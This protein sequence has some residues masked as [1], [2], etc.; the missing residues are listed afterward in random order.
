MAGRSF[1]GNASGQPE[2]IRLLRHSGIA[3]PLW[4]DAESRRLIDAGARQDAFLYDCC[5]KEVLMSTPRLSVRSL[6]V[7][8]SALACALPAMC[9]EHVVDLTAADGTKLKAT[10]FDAGKPG[11]GVLLLH[12]CNRQRKVWDGLALQLSGAG[13]NVLTVDT[14]GFG[15]SGGQRYEKLA[16]QVEAQIEKEK[17]P[18]D[19]DAAIQYLESQPGVTRDMIGVGGASCGVNNSIQTA[20]RHPEV[21]SLVLLSGNT[22]LNGRNYL[23]NSAKTPVFF[24]VADDDEFP[25]TVE[26]IEWLYSA[27]SNPGKR[28][29]HFTK[30]GHGADMFPVHPELPGAI[31]DWYVTTLIKTPGR[32]PV[33][34]DAPAIPQFARNLDLIDQPGGAGKVAAKLE[35][36]RKS[37]PTATLFPEAIVNTIG[38]EHLQAGDTKDAIEI[39][40]LNVAGF[41]QSPNT[42]DSLSD[43][44]MAAGQK[45]LARENVNKA[46][47]LLPS[48]TKD[49]APFREG[50][51]A[52]DEQKL[53]DL[54][55][56]GK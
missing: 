41:P 35:A 49:P 27:T 19:F 23:R 44:Y 45:D 39:F 1:S 42:Y 7:I 16:P 13:I 14:R 43:G 22:D 28:F 30:G 21:R 32:A 46:L 56:A 40:K 5:T 51:K 18:G 4:A 15:E 34:K 12:Q 2:D 8:L 9:A 38:Y 10:Y 6:T 55:D 24:A 25:P 48:D 31:V 17:W 3:E 33:T 20:R 26:A 50:L 53:K 36:A 11:P 54:A 52:T 37:D 29:L 47:E